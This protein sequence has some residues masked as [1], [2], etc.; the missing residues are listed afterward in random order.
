M[1]ADDRDCGALSDGRCFLR[2]TLRV[3]LQ[4]LAGLWPSVRRE[5]EL[6]DELESHLQMHTDDNLALGMSPQEAR[7]QAVLKLGGIEPVKEAWRERSSVPLIAH[8][9]QDGRFAWRQLRKN[10]AFACTAVF[11]LALG[12][13]ASVA[14]F[15]FVDAA[16]LTPLPYRDPAGLVAVYESVSMFPRSN[17]SYPDYLDWKAQN[18]SFQSLE[19]YGNRGMLLKTAAG[20]EAARGVRV[21]DGFFKTLGVAPALGRDFASGEDLPQAPRT[22]MLSYG[23]WQTRYGGRPDI[24]GQTVT[25]DGEANTIIGVLPK[26]FHFV[27]AEPADFW[28]TIHAAGECDLRRSCHSMYGV[29]RLKEGVSLTAALDDVK[30]IAKR[31]EQ[32]YPAMNRGQGAALAMLSDVIVGDVRPLL[33]MLLGGAVLLLVI[34]TVNVASLLLVRSES[35][36][37]EIAIRK[38]IGASIARLLSQFVTEGVLL[39]AAGTVV[40]LVLAYGAM[41]LLLKLIPVMMLDQLV[42][43]RNAGLHGHVLVFAGGLAML[44]V[45]LF[46]LTPAIRLSGAKTWEGLAEGSRGSAGLTWRRLGAK[47]VVLELA[48]AMVLLV[49][50]GLLT[51]SLYHLLRVDLGLQP[52]QLATIEV[53]APRAN[54]EKPEQQIALAN[55]LTRQFE[56]LPGAKSVGLTTTL[57]VSHNGNTSWFRVTGKA[58]PGGEHEEAPQRE[59]SPGYFPTIG[60]KLV[61]GRYFRPGEDR[62]KPRVAVLNEA[63]AR[64]YFP[65]QDAVGKHLTDI[66]EP[67]STMEVVG[68]VENVREGALDQPVPAVLY[69]PFEQSSDRYL[70]FLVRTAQ[71]SESAVLAS[72]KAAVRQVDPELAARPGKPMRLRINE[73]YTAYMHRSS[74]WLVGAFALVAL[75]LSGVGL[76]GVVAYSVSQ[77]SREIGVRMAMGAMPSA[78]YR[79]VL[80]E[81]GVLTLLG[82]V[83]GVAASLGAT[84]WIKGLLFGVQSWDVG[85][86]LVVA[87]VLAIAALLASFLPA[88]RA[89]MVNPVEALRA[90]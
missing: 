90:E 37:R 86:L 30:A 26:E 66:N 41:T 83:M 62:S 87:V 38:A 47:L 9:W 13:G 12:I 28:T 45:L 67:V 73:T 39:V 36:R 79:L 27:P 72:M 24:L 43:L 42:F 77:R 46:S 59:V 50:A 58:Y 19:L 44:A 8:L 76:Y 1:G 40:G 52:D 18:H 56:C 16:L 65:G 63:A 75:L 34:A 21:S 25:L 64:R 82:I 48:S 32:Q 61:R 3:W 68:V 23:A 71:S 74:A 22:V 6:A 10:P 80:G 29:A 81:A 20:S 89:A 60:A 57:P 70:C 17:L 14:I 51:Q 35:R 78:V 15:A 53:A 49:G 2:R 7:R 85:T 69:I 55:E 88:R 31:L 84:R 11:I 54:Y 5:Q 4:R 33:L